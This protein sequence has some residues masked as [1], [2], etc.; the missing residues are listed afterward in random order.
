MLPA[1]QLCYA[2]V[3]TCFATHGLMTFLSYL[4]DLPIS[5]SDPTYF[6]TLQSAMVRRTA[7]PSTL[8]AETSAH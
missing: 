7:R 5:K 6:E 8:E 4:S 3:A 2:A 1:L